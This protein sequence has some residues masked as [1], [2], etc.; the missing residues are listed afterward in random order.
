MPLLDVGLR[1]QATA[2]P[3]HQNDAASSGTRYA[4]L[5]LLLCT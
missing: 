1:W 2:L 5:N 3:F 4:Q